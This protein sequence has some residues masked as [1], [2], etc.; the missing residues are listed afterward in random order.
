[1]NKQVVGRPKLALP[2]EPERDR[3]RCSAPPAKE[4][5]MASRPLA[6]GGLQEAQRTH[7]EPVMHLESAPVKAELKQM[8]ANAIR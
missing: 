2:E 1:M 6:A 8:Q 3:Q 4:Q 5:P 7:L